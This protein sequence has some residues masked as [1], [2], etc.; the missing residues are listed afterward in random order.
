MS[1]LLTQPDFMTNPDPRPASSP[2]PYEDEIDLFELIGALWRAKWLIGLITVAA[3]AVAVS[4]ALLTAP[5][6]QTQA[7]TLPP[8][9]SDLAEYNAAYRL[10]EPARRAIV[11]SPE[12]AGQELAGIKELSTGGAYTAFMRQL[13]STQLRERFFEETYWPTLVK[14]QSSDS[15][16]ESLW[17]QLN[18][19]L[20]VRAPGNKSDQVPDEAVITFEGHTPQ[21][22]ADWTNVLMQMAEGEAIALLI[23]DLKTS[24]QSQLGSVEAQIDSLRA[25]AHDERANEIARLQA[26]LQMAQAIGLEEPP[27]SGNLITSYT[28]S[29]LYLRGARALQAEL[30]L[31]QERSSDDPYIEQLPALQYAQHLLKKV[32]LEPKDLSV[33]TVDRP[34]VRPWQPV[35]PKKRL[36]VALGVILGLMLGVGTALVRHAWRQHQMTQASVLRAAVEGS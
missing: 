33:V 22:I 4:Y 1:S 27:A 3:A 30:A 20:T 25:T 11:A 31:L 21:Q 34:A 28:G 24:V 29:T 5:T 2:S 9:I 12:S 13:Q 23:G 14:D 36:V 35:K 18:Q 8:T 15:E 32:N 17:R 19:Q 7:K 6:Y 10:L 16:R 26:A